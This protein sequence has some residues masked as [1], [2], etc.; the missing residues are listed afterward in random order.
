LFFGIT[1]DELPQIN[2]L[3]SYYQY[4]WLFISDLFD[5]FYHLDVIP[6]LNGY[7][8]TKVINVVLV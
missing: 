3:G 2:L 5:I 6:T 4:M 7:I 1:V 8:K